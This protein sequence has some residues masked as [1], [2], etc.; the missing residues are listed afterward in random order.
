MSNP[1]DEWAAGDIPP[2]ITPETLRTEARELR[3][4]SIGLEDNLGSLKAADALFTAASAW[5]AD[6]KRLV[7]TETQEARFRLQ[8]VQAQ[9]HIEALE[10][11]LNEAVDLLAKAEEE[12]DGVSP[13]ALIL[14]GI[15]EL[16][17]KDA[18]YPYL[19]GDFD[20]GLVKAAPPK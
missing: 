12:L 18:I 1:G 19:S 6:R 16:F 8:F 17:T 9:A 5:N 4:W 15:A 11:L 2:E 13:N 3:L 14:D 20:A 10:K 7:E